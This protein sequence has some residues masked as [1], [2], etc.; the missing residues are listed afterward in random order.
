M[1]ERDNRMDW[2]NRNPSVFLQHSRETVRKIDPGK[3]RC[4]LLGQS[5]APDTFKLL[6]T[7]KM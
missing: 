1:T 6:K 4:I 3:D 5:P 2:Q 7:L